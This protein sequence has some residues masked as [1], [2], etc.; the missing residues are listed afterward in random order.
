MKAIF[1]M[2]F[3]AL[4]LM[5]G[6][7]AAAEPKVSSLAPKSEPTKCYERAWGGKES[8]GLG[9]NAG[10]AVTLCS[11]ASDADK[12]IN[13]FVIAWSHRDDGG[14]GLN[15][16]QAVALCKTNLLP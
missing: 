10:Q 7:A 2:A 12:V 9:L 6:S 11:G 14:L 1:L 15:A 4:F 16:G 3:L 13:C 8:L 5:S